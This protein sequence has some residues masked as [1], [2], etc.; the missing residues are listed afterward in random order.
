MRT[1]HII[2]LAAALVIITCV[3]GCTN[4]ASPSASPSPTANVTGSVN[5]VKGK[6]LPDV[7]RYNS[8][9]RVS[10]QES[11]NT[12]AIV[13]QTNDTYSKVIDFY[14]SEMQSQG[15]QISQINSTNPATQGNYTQFAFT[16]GSTILH[17][18]IASE[19]QTGKT[20]IFVSE[21]K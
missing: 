8:S 20:D 11:N 1:K 17:V 2:V 18:T 19:T 21:V 5:D 4:P 6:D 16:K 13:Y 7:P 10:Y 15:Y 12:T 9:V 14:K 3:A